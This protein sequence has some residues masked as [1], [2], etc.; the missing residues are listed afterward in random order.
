[1]SQPSLQDDNES[2]LFSALVGAAVSVV[3]SFIPFSPI[4]GGAVAGYL[5]GSDRDLALKSGALSGVFLSLVG[6][7]IGAIVFLFFSF[8]AIFA[9][10]EVGLGLLGF[11]VI[12]LFVFALTLLYTVGLSALGGYLGAY[13]HE[14]FA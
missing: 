10:S 11:A 1:M 7:V 12:G 8:F 13:L 4:L 3:V 2:I 6:L 5:T 14:E 9:P